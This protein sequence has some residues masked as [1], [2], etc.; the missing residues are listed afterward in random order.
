M[1]KEDV[2]SE[3]FLKQFKTGEELY[4]FLAQIQKR[5]V[6]Q[7]LEGELDSHLGYDK[8]QATAGENT[9]NGHSKKKIKNQFGI[10]EI[11]VPR[12]RDASFSPALVPKRKNMAEGVENIIISLYAKGM[13]VSDIEEQ[14]RE[15]YNIELS[16]SAISRITERVSQDITLWQNR[17][18][19][20]VYCIVWMDGIVFKVREN[21]RVIDKTIY[22]AIGLRTDGKKEVLGL[23]LGKN[24]SAAFWLSVLTDLRSRGVQDILITATDNLKGFTDAIR[25]VFP[26]STKQICIVHQIRNACRY[27]VWKDRKAF[28]ADMKEIYTAPNR[29][30]A[31]LALDQLEAV[32]SQKY[33]YAIKSWRDNWEELTAFLAF[34]M[35]IRKIIY[36]TNIIENLNGKIRKYT[37]N[38][39]SY[40]TDDAVMKSV[41]LAVNESTKKWTM[42]IRDWGTI[43]NQFM[44]MFENRLKF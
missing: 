6:E 30:A 18:L 21:S 1:K 23:W 29:E 42:P 16:T 10:A 28:T 20:S 15:L 33:G 24:E 35:E 13:S 22:I 11:Q 26:E 4:S 27:V 3:E 17:P 14:I 8:H 39:L 44:I 7:I 5:G 2:L 25:S 36:T 40:P 41:F 32:W 34:P 12:D 43:L 9:R 38:K 19:E 31:A 37:K